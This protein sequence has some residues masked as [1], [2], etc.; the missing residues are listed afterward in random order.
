MYSVAYSIVKNDCD[1]AEV[2]SESIY[3]AYA[4][5]DNLKNYAVFKTWILR[6][7]H[8]TAVEYVRKNYK[9]IMVDDY[10]QNYDTAVSNELETK[11]VL[12][13]AIESL[14]QPYRTV[15]VLFYYEG[16]STNDI[17]NITGASIINVRKQL[18]RARTMLKQILKEDF[19]NE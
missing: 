2:I 14:K 11:I 9:Y 15:V 16:L 8:N 5:L 6:I 3:R 4:N 13:Q 10:E 1:C 18:Q 17:S 19:Q 12:K 7:V